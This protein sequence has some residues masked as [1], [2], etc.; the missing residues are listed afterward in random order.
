M[1]IDPVGSRYIVIG[2][3]IDKVAAGPKPGKTPTNVPNEQ[4]RKQ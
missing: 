1:M 4:P 3:N 2:N